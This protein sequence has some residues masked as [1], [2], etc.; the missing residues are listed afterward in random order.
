MKRSFLSVRDASR[1]DLDLIFERTKELKAEIRER[2]N[3]NSLKNRIVGILF[4]KPST[5]TRTSFEA[6]TL[7]L[8]GQALYLPSSELQLSRGEPVKDTA[9]ILG[10]YL[11]AIVARVYA[12]D[13]VVQLSKYSKIPVINGLSDLEHPTQMVCDL[14]TIL[15]VKGELEGLTL[16]FIGDGNNMCNSWLLGAAAVGMNMVAACPNGY[17][18]DK[19][20]FEK[21][22]KIAK[23]TGVELKIVKSPKDAAQEADILYTDVWVSMGEEKEKARRLKAFK[24]YQINSALVKA[25]AKDAIVMHCLP[26]HRG[27]E[28]T[29]DVI[30][31]KQSVVWTQGENKLYGAAGILDF[32]LGT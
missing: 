7:R 14:F 17:H 15:E 29:D 20:I 6:A 3:I 12:H 23:K 10:G 25:A 2:E 28:I 26:A 9:R 30:E 21:A 24:G 32:F 11:D 16:A 31:G 19:G 18:P 13:T 5:R 8:G 27:L 1:Q 22:K 4:E